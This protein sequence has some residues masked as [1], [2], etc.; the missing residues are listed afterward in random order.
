MSFHTG[1]HT[2][3]PT[4]ADDKKDT[5]SRNNETGTVKLLLLDVFH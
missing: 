2:L 1:S 4:V 5:G 3:I